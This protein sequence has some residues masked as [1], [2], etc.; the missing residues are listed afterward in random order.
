MVWLDLATN[1]DIREK[2]TLTRISQIY[3]ENKA[4][5][6]VELTSD[7]KI[8]GVAEV[9]VEVLGLSDEDFDRRVITRAENVNNGGALSGSEMDSGSVYRNPQTKQFCPRTVFDAVLDALSVDEIILWRSSQA[10]AKRNG[11]QPPLLYDADNVDVQAQCSRRVRRQS[12][13][14]SANAEG[15]SATAARFGVVGQQ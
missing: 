7:E 3:A 12:A 6:K 11:L 4:A 15:Q 8:N 1:K 10:S 13:D 9:K 2:G 5:T 14:C